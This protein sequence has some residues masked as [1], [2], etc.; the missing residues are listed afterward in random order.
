MK[1]RKRIPIILCFLVLAVILA[2]CGASAEYAPGDAQFSANQ[3][4]ESGDVGTSFLSSIPPTTERLVIMNADLTIEVEDPADSIDFISQLA[5]NYHGFVVS[6]DLR[7]VIGARGTVVPHATIT[8]RV[9]A[10]QLIR[11]LEEIEA[12]AIEVQ[13]KSQSGQDVTK[14]YTD[15]QSRLRNLEDTAKQ[16]R[17]IMEEARNT[18]AVLDVYREL[19]NVTEEIEV[20]RGQI[21]YYDESI[22]FSAISV[23]LITHEEIKPIS[24]GGWQPVGVARDAVQAL[25]DTLQVIVNIFIWLVIY[26][27]PVLAVLSLSYMAVGWAYRKWLKPKPK[28]KKSNE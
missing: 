18:D 8:I 20:I 3:A 6:S 23:T 9:P 28:K 27:A 10:D 22:A 5:Q 14:E 11:V 2:S 17:Q 26:V 16:L 4:V 13:S 25:V 19:T 24:I 21:Q 12:Q 15:L 7:Q 1:T